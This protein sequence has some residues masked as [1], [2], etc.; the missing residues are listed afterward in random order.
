MS[1]IELAKAFDSPLLSCEDSN[2]V[3]GTIVK[4]IGERGVRYGVVSNGVVQGEETFV[5]GE[6]QSYVNDALQLKIADADRVDPPQKGLI[7]W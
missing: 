5:N 6:G 1:P 2:A 7:F 4:R 3:V